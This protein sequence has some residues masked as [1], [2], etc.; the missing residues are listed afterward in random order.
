MRFVKVNTSSVLFI[1]T[2]W[3]NVQ[4]NID[5]L[6]RTGVGEAGGKEGP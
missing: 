3:P 2:A 4:V 1:G 6:V 5:R